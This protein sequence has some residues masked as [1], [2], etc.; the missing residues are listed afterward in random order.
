LIRIGI[1]SWASVLKVTVTLVA[2]LSW[3]TDGCAT[4]GN[5]VSERVD[6]TSLVSASKTHGVVLTVD[7]NVL[8]VTTFKLLDGS[9]DILHTTWLA[10]LL[11]GEVAVETSSVPV[12]RNWLWVEGDLGTEFFGDTVKKE[13]SK[14][15]VITH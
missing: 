12:S 10:H 8:L 7:G 6:A 11:A 5:T 9:L 14:P 1:G 3:D 15:K 2:T 13:A 4:V